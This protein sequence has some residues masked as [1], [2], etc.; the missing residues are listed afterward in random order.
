MPLHDINRLNLSPAKYFVFAVSIRKN[1][2]NASIDLEA[3]SIRSR[4]A[5]NQALCPDNE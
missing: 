1:V 2:P 4:Q 5:T 3:A